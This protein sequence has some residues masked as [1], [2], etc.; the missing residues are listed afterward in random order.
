MIESVTDSKLTCPECAHQ[1]LLAMPIDVCLW[2][3]KYGPAGGF[4]LHPF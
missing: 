3:H 1:E 2:F 4:Y